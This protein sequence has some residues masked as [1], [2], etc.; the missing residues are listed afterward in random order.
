MERSEN[1]QYKVGHIFSETLITLKNTPHFEELLKFI[2]IIYF[3]RLTTQNTP[4]FEE[5][6]KFIDIIIMVKFFGG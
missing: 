3:W 4:H 2:I 1:R 6:L 5:L